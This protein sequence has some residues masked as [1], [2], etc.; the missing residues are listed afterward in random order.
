MVDYDLV[1]AV[2]KAA[3]V[4]EF[5]YALP[6]RYDTVVGERGL[7]LSGGQRQRVAIAQAM[8]KQ[9]PSWCWT[10]PPRPSTPSPSIWSRRRCG[11]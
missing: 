3:H 1:H 11:G 2:G 7:K 4:E 5:V 9:A 6:D 8:A 10:R